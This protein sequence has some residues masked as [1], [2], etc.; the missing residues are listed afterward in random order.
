L[1]AFVEKHEGLYYQADISLAALVGQDVKFI[2]T[3][4]ATG[5]PSGDRAVWVAPIISNTN[6]TA[7]LPVTGTPTRTPTITPTSTITPTPTV[8]PTAT[9]TVP[10]P[11]TYKLDFGTA[12]SPLE[13]GY[14]RVTETNIFSSGGFGWV[15]NSGLSS[16]D[17][18]APNALRQDFVLNDTSSA[19]IFRM[20]IANGTYN[21]TVVMGDNDYAHDNMVVKANGTTVLADVDSTAGAF[22][23]NVFSVTVSDG[24]LSLE[25]SDAGGTDPTWVVNAIDVGP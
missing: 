7:T 5:S 22:A 6:P 20:A 11:S 14:T 1:W 21:V 25:F 19:R 2:L 12:S 17:R 9:A 8:T 24:L 16:R 23:S 13:T 18:S 4:L 15:D 3:V 10:A